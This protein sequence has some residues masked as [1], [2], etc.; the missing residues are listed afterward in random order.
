M[1]GLVSVFQQWALFIGFTLAMGCVAWR[2]IVAPRATQLLPGDRQPALAKLQFVV[3]SVGVVTG[4][5]LIAAW[6]LRLVAQV[7]GFRDPFVPLWEDVSFLLFEVPWGAVWMAQGVVVALLTLSFWSARRSA[8]ERPAASSVGPMGWPWQA[9]TILVLGLAATLALSGH[10][11]G[12]ESRRGLFLTADGLHTVAAG[13][14]IGSLTLILWVGRRV[15][16]GPADDL[17]AAQIR[18]FSPMALVCVGVLLSMGIALAWTHLTAISD[19]WLLPYGRVLS[20][21]V[22]VAGAVFAAGFLNWRRGVPALDTESALS[23]TRR[24]AVWE[25]SLAV[26]VLLL[27][28]VLVHSPLP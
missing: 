11:F 24:R 13:S 22:G 20:G 21:K 28:A 5:V 26:C 9:A 27:T 8:G 4:F 1:T 6:V 15:D 25:V 18:S 2:V 7:M 16:G 19:L 10:A 14:W 3:A 12:L 17:F 23:A